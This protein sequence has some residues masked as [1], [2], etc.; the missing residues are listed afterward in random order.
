MKETHWA[1]H[2]LVIC[3]ILC[4]SLALQAGTAESVCVWNMDEGSGDGLADSSGNGFS[5]SAAPSGTLEWVDGVSGEAVRLP[6][7]TR[8]TQPNLLSAGLPEGTLQF[9]CRFDPECKPGTLLSK[10]NS[11]T[12]NAENAIWITREKDGRIEFHSY[13]SGSGTNVPIISKLVLLPG[14]WYHVALTWGPSGRRLYIDGIE[15]AADPYPAALGEGAMS[16]FALGGGDIAA[17][18]DELRV[19]PTSEAPT[20]EKPKPALSLM[21]V[22]A[23]PGCRQGDIIE[24]SLDLRVEKPVDAESG[25]EIRLVKNDH[26]M[27]TQW[28]AFSTRGTKP[29]QVLRVGP[30]KFDTFDAP[31]GKHVFVLRSG[32][33]DIKCP[34]DGGVIAGITV[35]GHK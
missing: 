3:T 21:K 24:L 30:A 31:E 6:P 19:L 1:L 26:T 4:C 33:A 10:T 20:R 29:G 32:H 34:R 8:I 5:G 25:A 22:I 11:M 13:L 23:P 35:K 7:G 15:E 27:S 12:N 17:S 16:E 14:E 28:V 9:W 2:L 18:F